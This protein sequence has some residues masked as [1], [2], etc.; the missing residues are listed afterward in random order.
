M[1][2]LFLQYEISTGASGVVELP[3]GHRKALKLLVPLYWRNRA[4]PSRRRTMADQPSVLPADHDPQETKE[5]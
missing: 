1:R 2:I 5:W 3:A 4:K